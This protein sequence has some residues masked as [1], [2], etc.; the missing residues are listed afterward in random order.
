MQAGGGIWHKE[1]YEPRAGTIGI[2]Q[3]W[4]QLPPGEEDGPVRYINRQPG[5]IPSV[6]NTRVLVGAFKG[7]AAD[8]DIPVRMTYLDVALHQGNTWTFTPPDGQTCGFLLARSE[9]LNVSGTSVPSLRLAVLV[10]SPETIEVSAV[11]DSKFIAVVAE[12][13]LYPIVHEHGQMH[14]NRASLERAKTRI[15]ELAR[16]GRDEFGKS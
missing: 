7:V 15:A 6:D 13:S 14:T 3:L 10:D 2:I 9:A 16:T 8:V 4:L 12:P 11:E 1:M 5:E